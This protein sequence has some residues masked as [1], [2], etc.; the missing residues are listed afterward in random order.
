MFLTSNVLEDIVSKLTTCHQAVNRN[1]KSHQEMISFSCTDV[2]DVVLDS[3]RIDI[4]DNHSRSSR[5][6]NNARRLFLIFY[7]AHRGQAKHHGI[8]DNN[9]SQH[10]ACHSLQASRYNVDISFY[11]S[12]RWKI[13]H[14]VVIAT[15]NTFALIYEQRN[16]QPT[17]PD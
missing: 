3:R 8:Q 11:K 15:T 7:P 2:I 13:T 5:V 6:W 1:Q 12:L 10:L 16:F 14:Q 9:R 17:D 4:Y